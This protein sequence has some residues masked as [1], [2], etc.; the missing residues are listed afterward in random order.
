MTITKKLKIG[1]VC[2][3]TVGGSGI[4]ATQ[5]GIALAKLGH[6]I[7]FISYQRPFRLPTQSKNIYFHKVPINTYQLFRYPD[8]T[9]PLAVTMTDVHTKYKLDIMHVHY[10]VPHATAALLAKQIIT[11]HQKIKPFKV[12]TTLHGTDITLVGNDQSLK[13]VICYSIGKSDGI[14]AVSKN[15]ATET[16]KIFCINNPIEVIYNFYS[17]KKITKSPQLIRRELGLNKNTFVISHASNLRP[18]KRIPDLLKIFS[19]VEKKHDAKLLIL[20]GGDFS[21]YLPLAK[22]LKIEKKII[23]KQ[24]V[25]DVENYLNAADCGLYTSDHESFGMSILETMS[26]GKP[27]LATRAGGVPEVITNRLNGLLYQV[28]DI[29]GFTSGIDELINNKKL[30]QNISSEGKIKAEHY[31]SAAKMVKKYLD[32]YSKILAQN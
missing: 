31:F 23:L 18:V 15:L 12:I 8:Y 27:V 6:K 16:K 2:Y 5:L 19:Q 14:T 9:L 32:Y 10:A 20:S 24:N 1:I 11:D 21:P 22:K 17:P 30:W 3:P 26:Y 7:H 28:G 4:V 25:A 29:N 13:P